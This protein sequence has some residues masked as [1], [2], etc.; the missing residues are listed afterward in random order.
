MAAAQGSYNESVRLM[1]VSSGEEILHVTYNDGLT[2]MAFT[3]DARYLAVLS[4]EH[5]LTFLDARTG[6][7]V[8]TFA[9]SPDV[10]WFRFLPDG[11]LVTVG[12]TVITWRVM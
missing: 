7:S 6:E 2:A 4:R 3:P 11:T 8:N 10:R 12:S 9:V 1:N 5:G